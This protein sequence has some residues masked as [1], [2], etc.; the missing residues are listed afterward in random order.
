MSFTNYD[1]AVKEYRIPELSRIFSKR[2]TC[3][4]FRHSFV[5]HFL[6]SGYDITRVQ[7]LF[8][9]KN[10]ETTMTCTHVRG[11][12]AALAGPGKD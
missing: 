1:S 2:V 8:G 7:A 5:T 3:H 4:I 9:H 11:R 6:K 10:V 12:P